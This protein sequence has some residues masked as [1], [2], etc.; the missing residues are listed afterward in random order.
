MSSNKLSTFCYKI[1]KAT[2]I[3]GLPCTEKKPI[4]CASSIFFTQIQS[5]PKLSAMHTEKKHY[6]VNAGAHE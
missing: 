1:I 3:Y 2:N 5:T 4:G 6:N